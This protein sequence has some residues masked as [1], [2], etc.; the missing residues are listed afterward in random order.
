MS[1]RDAD[2]DIISIAQQ[3]KPNDIG[4]MEFFRP[5]LI[6]LSSVVVIT[7][8]C[9]NSCSKLSLSIRAKRSAGPLA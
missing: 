1:Y 6:T 3:A 4:Q 8:A 2:I 7:P 9:S 5:Q